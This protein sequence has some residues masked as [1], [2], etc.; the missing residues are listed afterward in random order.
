MAVSFNNIPAGNGIKTPLFFAEFDQSAANTATA[1][2]RRLIIASV[3]DDATAPEIGSLT[4]CSSLAEA[5]RIGGLGS[6]LATM[7][8]TWR[9]NDPM[10]EVWVL[11]LKLSEGVA[12]TGSI[13]I[14]GTATESGLLSVYL[15]GHLVQCTVTD[16]MTADNLGKALEDAINAEITLP[17]KAKNTT[18][19][20]ALTCKFK[21]VLGNDIAIE[22]NRL[23]QSNGQVTPSGLSIEI[24][25]MAS[26]TGAPKSADIASAIG[27]EGFEFICQPWTDTESLDGWKDIMNDASGRWSY[28]KMLFG[29]VY[30]AMRGT[31]SELVTAGQKRNDQHMTIVGVEKDIPNTLYDF[32]SAYTARQAVFISADPARPTQTGILV[33]ISPSQASNRWKLEERNTLLGYGIATS[34]YGGGNVCIERAITTYQKNS[35]GQPDNSYMDSETMHTLAYIVNFLKSRITS[36]FGRHKLANDGTR[37]G[38]GQAIVTPKI[39]KGELIACY[40]KLEELGLVENA[41]QFEANLIVERDT[42]NVNRI[43]VLLPPD[44]VNQLRIFALL[45]Q[46]RLQY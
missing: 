7:Y 38:P 35:Y 27:D 22:M 15:G 4:L 39:V 11:P 18:G 24:T 29:H 20:V 31:V 45:C 8:E 17:V 30:S 32:I 16:K 6:M 2:M 43:N 10:G 14:T 19:T 36:K 23:G 3:N 33:G 41:E 37:F 40:N 26:G 44:L 5:R 13:K 42:V 46:F 28:T 12:S 9:A 34:Y 1:S 25:K 21:G